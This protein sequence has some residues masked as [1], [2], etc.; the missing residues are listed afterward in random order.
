[1]MMEIENLIRQKALSGEIS[2]PL[3][4]G[5]DGAN[6]LDTGAVEEEL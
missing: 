6:T 2:L 4:M 1:M 5:N 3:D